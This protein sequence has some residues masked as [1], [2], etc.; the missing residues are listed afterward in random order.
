MVVCKP[1]IVF[2]FVQRQFLMSQ[3]IQEQYPVSVSGEKPHE[4]IWAGCGKVDKNKFQSYSNYQNTY[5]LD[6]AEELQF[7]RSWDRFYDPAPD[8][9]HNLY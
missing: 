2:S 7:G 4:N 5:L 8:F 3:H 1:I 6:N 9:H